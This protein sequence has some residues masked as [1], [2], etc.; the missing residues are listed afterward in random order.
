MNTSHSFK[1]LLVA[2]ALALGLAGSTVASTD[3]VPAAD[4]APAVVGQGLLGQSFYHASYGFLNLDDTSVDAHALTLDYNRPVDAT[5][6]TF[7]SAR[8][9]RS[10]SLPGGRYSE[11]AL[12]FGARFHT[13]FHGVKPYWDAGIGWTWAKGP[14]GFRDNTFAW[15]SSIGVEVPTSFGLS[16]T[17]YVQYADAIDFA[18]GDSWNVGVKGNYWL[19]D[20][21]AVFVGVERAIEES[22]EYRLGMNFRF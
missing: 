8:F 10:G 6:D 12:N 15:S 4:A 2:G 9:L 20:R 3:P 18:E 22:W 17:P 5:L 1:T 7:A 21:T 14:G 16:L 19:N 13:L 11:Q